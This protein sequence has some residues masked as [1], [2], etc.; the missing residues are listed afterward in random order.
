MA[1]GGRGKE[2]AAQ[3]LSRF[4]EGDGEID[5]R[6]AEAEQHARRQIRA[7]RKRARAE[8]SALRCCGLRHTW[9]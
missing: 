6:E 1:R 2:L 8:V 5:T 9:E 7:L 3:V 4:S